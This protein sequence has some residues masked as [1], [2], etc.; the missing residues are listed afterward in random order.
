MNAGRKPREYTARAMKVAATALETD[1]SPL[2][3]MI[4]IMTRH[5]D[6]GEWDKA[7]DAAS[8]AAPYVHPKL[9]A[10]EHSTDNAQPLFVFASYDQDV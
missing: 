10:V 1:K 5:F 8:K 4:A 7:L 3:V 2:A 9:A 6:A